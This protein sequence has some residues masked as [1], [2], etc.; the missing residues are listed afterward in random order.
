MINLLI[1]VVEILTFIT[2]AAAILIVSR[3]FNQRLVVQRRLGERKDVQVRQRSNLLKSIEV[4]NPFLNWIQTTT[5]DK[6]AKE[7]SDL[8]SKL[9]LAGYSSPAAPAIFVTLRLVAASVLPVLFVLSQ[10]FSAHPITGFRA[11]L[12]ALGFSAIG[13]IGPGVLLDG[14]VTARRQAIETEFP[15]ALDPMVVCVESGLGLEGAI[16]RVGQETTVSHPMVSRELRSV[17]LELNAGRSRPDALRSLATRTNIDSIRSFVAL[18]IQTDQLGVSYAK[19]LRTFSAELREKRYM[20]AE[21][22]AMRIPLLITIP[23]VLCILPALVI[24]A[25]LPAMIEAG[26]GLSAMIQGSHVK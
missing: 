26:H 6:D 15:D 22:K 1:T 21:E 16:L 19:T 10:S 9:I 20:N 13:L 17:S 8:Q 3:H 18:L 2:V 12:F 24:A 23:L 25:M 4:K 5:L 14:R 7:K 11:I